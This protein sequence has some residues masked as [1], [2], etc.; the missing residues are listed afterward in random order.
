MPGRKH[1]R[2]PPFV[3]HALLTGSSHNLCTFVEFWFLD[4]TS[5]TE[6]LCNVLHEAH[7]SPDSVPVD[8]QGST[9]TGHF[10]TMI[11][12][13]RRGTETGMSAPRLTGLYRSRNGRQW[14]RDHPP[15]LHKM[16]LSAESAFV[17]CPVLEHFSSAV[18]SQAEP[19]R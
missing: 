16:G 9:P 15:T 1:Q 10:F 19:L 7:L 13:A 4:V 18:K 11:S 8:G 5:R 14:R 12:G 17:C 6:S 3:L 2:C